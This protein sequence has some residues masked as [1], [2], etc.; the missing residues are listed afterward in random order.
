M[1]KLT[2][3]QLLSVQNVPNCTRSFVVVAN[4]IAVAVDAVICV[5][6][7]VAVVAV[8][9]AAAAALVAHLCPCFR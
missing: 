9:A 5:F 6:A 2:K 4:A 7:V 1:V 3:Q 8:V